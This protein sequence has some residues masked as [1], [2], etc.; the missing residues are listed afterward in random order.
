MLESVPL[1]PQ[2][3]LRMSYLDFFF[4]SRT[5]SNNVYKTA[6]EGKQHDEFLSVADGKTKETA[7]ECSLASH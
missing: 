6:S 1:V 3:P 2:K 7:R 5:T 4:R